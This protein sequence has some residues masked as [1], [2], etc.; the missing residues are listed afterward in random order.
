MYLLKASESAA[1]TQMKSATHFGVHRNLIEKMESPL[2]CNSSCNGELEGT[3]IRLQKNGGGDL[4]QENLV[5]KKNGAVV[6]RLKQ[7]NIHGLAC[8]LRTGQAAT[9]L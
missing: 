7:S 1:A 2:S 3:M 8:R 9:S 6:A 5:V 4:E